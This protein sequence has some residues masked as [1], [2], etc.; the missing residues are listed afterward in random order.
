[1]GEIF[2][3]KWSDVLY[4]EGLLAVGARFKH[5]KVRYV[6]M[7]PELA[8][9]FRHYPRSIGDESRVSCQEQCKG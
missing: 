5:G 4:G 2:N 7:P 1:M 3:L 6:P 8:E 9:E